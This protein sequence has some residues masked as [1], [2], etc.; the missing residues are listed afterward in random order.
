[1]TS[2]SPV[3]TDREAF[4]AALRTTVGARLSDDTVV[5]LFDEGWREP[6]TRRLVTAT[7]RMIGSGSRLF[8]RHA[9]P[10]WTKPL[11]RAWRM[12]ALEHAHIW[13]S[14]HG[15]TVDE[16]LNW[17]I[18]AASLPASAYEPG[19]DRPIPQPGVMQGWNAILGDRA[20]LGWAAGLSL[21]EA[22]EKHLSGTADYDTWRLLAILRGYEAVIEDMPGR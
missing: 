11:K 13:V 18:A 7:G 19:A 2:P 16:A 17:L 4:Q 22:T 1:M 5:E 3:L 12:R 15:L 20:I 6:H 14:Q 9:S 21:Y 8:F 10:G